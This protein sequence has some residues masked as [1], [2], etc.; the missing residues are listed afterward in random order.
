MKRL[1]TIYKEKCHE[2]P[3][4]SA[5]LLLRDWDTC[6]CN[7]LV[8]LNF[9]LRLLLQFSVSVSLDLLDL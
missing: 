6:C 3:V 2:L 8:C 9:L 7:R 5:F 1:K 4:T